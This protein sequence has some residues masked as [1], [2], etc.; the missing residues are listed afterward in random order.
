MNVKLKLV[1]GKHNG[2]VIEVRSERFIIGRGE[3]CHLRPSSE[4]VSRRHCALVMQRNRVQ[5]CDLK[6]SN[7]TFVNGVR[8]KGEQIL[9][10]GDLVKVGPLE[11][12]VQFAALQSKPLR[13]A[14]AVLLMR[15]SPGSILRTRPSRMILSSNG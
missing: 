5:I 13:Q 12:A 14:R 6:S 15:M 4:A 1:G 8:V 3:E 9:Q 10:S 2:K 7:G 11:F